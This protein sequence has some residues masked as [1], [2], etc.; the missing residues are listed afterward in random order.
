M[1]NSLRD[2]LAERLYQLYNDV[3]RD[4]SDADPPNVTERDRHMVVA[5]RLLESMP[6]EE[7]MAKFIYN[8]QANPIAWEANSLQERW[9]RIAARLREHMGVW[10]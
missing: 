10:I 4:F 8:S 1:T 5:S 2:K 6:G 7:E 3:D 9:L